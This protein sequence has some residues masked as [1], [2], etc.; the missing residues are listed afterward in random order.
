M[1]SMRRLGLSVCRR[2]KKVPPAHQEEGLP[3]LADTVTS[4][5]SEL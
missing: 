3:H 2:G 5:L 4:D 1:G